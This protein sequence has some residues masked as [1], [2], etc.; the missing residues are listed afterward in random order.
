MKELKKELIEIRNNL[1][2]GV[3]N[4]DL[5]YIKKQI[6]RIDSLICDVDKEKKSTEDF[7]ALIDRLQ[8]ASDIKY[9]NRLWNAAFKENVI[10]SWNGKYDLLLARVLEIEEEIK[11]ITM[12]M[13]AKEGTKVIVTEHTIKNGYYSVKE[14]A[15]LHLVVGETYTVV[16]TDVDGWSTAVHLKEIPNEIFNSISFEDIS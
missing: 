6:N 11:E 10:I 9:P 5:F 3:E 7:N 4:N 13:Y 2:I 14:Y 15:K 16:N 12:D 8:R 1:L